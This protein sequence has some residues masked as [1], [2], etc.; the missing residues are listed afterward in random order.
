MHM[1]FDVEC[2]YRENDYSHKKKTVYTLKFCLVLRGTDYNI[3]IATLFKIAENIQWAI[4]GDQTL[5]IYIA[6][7][8]FHW[9]NKDKDKKIELQHFIIF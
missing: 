4:F 2:I 3:K 5:M 9:F 8:D 6:V 7:V 1:R